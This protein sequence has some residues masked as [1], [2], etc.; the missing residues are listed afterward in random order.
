MAS[1]ARV[2]LDDA[3]GRVRSRPVDA[4]GRERGA[5]GEAVVRAAVQQQRAAAGCGVEL[6]QRREAA[7]AQVLSVEA[8]RAEQ[9]GVARAGGGRRR[10]P[11]HHLGDAGRGGELEPLGVAT[12]PQHVHV[13]VDQPRHDR[14]C[15]L[16]HGRAGRAGGARLGERSRGRHPPADHADGAHPRAAASSVI[17]SPA[18]TTAG[19]ASLVGG[20]PCALRTSGWPS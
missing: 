12:A 13:R 9:P 2:A 8:R 18:T 3:A 19:V 1:P 15:K 6:D 5:V 17:T 14:A 20:S 11:G 4:G 10:D 16:E 7:L